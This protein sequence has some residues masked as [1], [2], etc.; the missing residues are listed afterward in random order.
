MYSSS[1]CF[2]FSFAQVKKKIKYRFW[3]A[4]NEEIC[5]QVLEEGIVPVDRND[6]WARVQ[7]LRQVLVPGVAGVNEF[8]KLKK[9]NKIRKIVFLNQLKLW[10]IVTSDQLL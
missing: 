9:K 1:I 7:C 5:S 8:K 10:R 6:F 3:G 4:K 2:I